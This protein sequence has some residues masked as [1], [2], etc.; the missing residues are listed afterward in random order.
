[1]DRAV[2]RLADEIRKARG[3]P[4]AFTAVPE[5]G[6][7]TARSGDESECY[8]AASLLEHEFPGAVGHALLAV[9][10]RV[11]RA[12]GWVGRSTRRPGADAAQPSVTRLT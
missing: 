11:R 4:V 9:A 5:V 7:V 2:M 6:A 3:E 12:V 1:M 10:A 8:E